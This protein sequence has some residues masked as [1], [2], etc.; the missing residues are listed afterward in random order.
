MK[1][2][3]KQCAAL[4]AAVEREP[5]FVILPWKCGA[6]DERMRHSRSVVYNDITRLEGNGNRARNAVD[7][8]AVPTPRDVGDFKILVQ[9]H[10]IEWSGLPAGIID[11]PVAAIPSLVHFG[12]ANLMAIVANLPMGVVESP[13]GFEDSLF[14]FQV[15]HALLEARERY[16]HGER[17]PVP[18]FRVP[19]IR[20]PGRQLWSAAFVGE[21]CCARV[22]HEGRQLLFLVCDMGFYELVCAACLPFPAQIHSSG[23]SSTMA[24]H[25]SIFSAKVACV[26]MFTR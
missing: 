25:A 1:K 9:L 16:R 14:R 26:D 22:I 2:L 11:V 24:S 10:V 8:S 21:V 5:A 4:L 23:I 18:M 15:R 19:G 12:T 17:V 13:T 7:D 20:H 6:K 3:I